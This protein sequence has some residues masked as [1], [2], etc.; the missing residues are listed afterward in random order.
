MLFH[1]PDD[2]RERVETD[3]TN[4]VEL[5]PTPGC[6]ANYSSRYITVLLSTKTD[7]EE[8]L[9]L[10]NDDEGDPLGER[11]HVLLWSI[12]TRNSASD[13]EHHLTSLGDKRTNNV[14]SQLT[15]YISP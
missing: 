13:V 11:S 14:A 9:T 8:A 4:K 15:D 1:N 6:V 5:T 12:A 3:E 7:H 2:N 10:R